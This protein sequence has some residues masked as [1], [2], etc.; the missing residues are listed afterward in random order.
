MKYRALV[1][2]TGLVSMAKGEVREISD[3]S[4]ANGLLKAKYIE[5]VKQDE[6]KA[7]EKV[8]V[9]PKD[10]TESPMPKKTKTPKKK[11]SKK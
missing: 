9:E 1:S 4:I 10:E 3:L 2:F 7:E 11:E 5:Q 6:V 8:K